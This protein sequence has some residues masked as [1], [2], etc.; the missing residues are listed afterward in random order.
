MRGQQNAE[1]I[2][3]SSLSNNVLQRSLAAASGD[4][5]RLQDVEFFFH[6]AGVGAHLIEHYRSGAGAGDPYHPAL[7]LHDHSDAGL[8]RTLYEEVL[9]RG[10][11]CWIYGKRSPDTS[12]PILERK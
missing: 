10:A 12:T 6:A 7:I 3:E 11:R 2:S 9:A 1:V 4:A 5:K 8:A